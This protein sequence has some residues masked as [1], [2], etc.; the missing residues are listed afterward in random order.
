MAVMQQGDFHFIVQNPK[1]QFSKDTRT[2]IRKQAMRAVGIARRRSDRFPNP[3][4]PIQH[5]LEQIRLT[6][7]VPLSG[8]ELLVKDSGIDPR[9]LS[10]LTC[11]HIG[12]VSVLLI[13]Y[14]FQRRALIEQCHRASQ[15]LA[16]EPHRLSAVMRCRQNSYFNCIMPRFGYTPVLDDAFSC[17]LTLTRSILVP[18][19]N[20]RKGTIL[21]NYLKALSSLQSTINDPEAWHS[22]EVLCATAILAVFEVSKLSTQAANIMLQLLKTF[23]YLTRRMENHGASTLRGQPVSFNL[24]VRPSLPHS[25]IE[26]FSYHSLSL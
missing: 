8:I 7:T 3:C 19:P 22:T 2:K 5:D 20:S 14:S 21:S 16:S 1:E 4:P 24:E 10:A 15:L 12:M 23:S 9:D 6:Q 26:P 13:D 25:S 17:L 11:V 18:S